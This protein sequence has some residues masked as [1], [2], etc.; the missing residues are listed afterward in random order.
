MLEVYQGTEGFPYPDMNI[1]DIGG[2]YDS[3]IIPHLPL[4][5]NEA[6]EIAKEVNKIANSLQSVKGALTE[7]GEKNPE[8]KIAEII[9]ERLDFLEQGG[10]TYRSN[11]ATPEPMISSPTQAGNPTMGGQPGVGNQAPK[12]PNT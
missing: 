12:G 7:L 6:E 10:G 8:R 4:P 5:E 1:S 2:I 11:L 3:R 9:K